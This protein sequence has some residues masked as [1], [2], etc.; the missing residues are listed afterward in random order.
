MNVGLTCVSSRNSPTS[1]SK[2][3]PVL[4]THKYQELFEFL[5]IPR[6]RKIL[7]SGQLLPQ[8]FRKLFSYVD[9]LEGWGAANPEDLAP[10]SSGW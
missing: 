6:Q 9:F 2:S 5:Q 3:P 10:G 7:V 1:L 8:G 4:F